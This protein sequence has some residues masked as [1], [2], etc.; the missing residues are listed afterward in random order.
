MLPPDLSHL[1]LVTTGTWRAW[2]VLSAD[3]KYRYL[4]GR[5][6]EEL[7]ADE[8]A[9]LGT[10]S[11]WEVHATPTI[12][13]M[14]NPSTADALTDDPTIRRCIGFARKSGR[15]RLVVANLFAWRA[16]DPKALT[17]TPDPVGPQNQ[18]AIRWAVNLFGDA[19]AAWG[20]FPSKRVRNLAIRS[21]GTAKM[22]TTLHCYGKTKDGEPRHPLMLPYDT[23]R[24]MLNGR[25]DA[26][27]RHDT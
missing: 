12:F 9:L 26:T 18:E 13:V 16:T 23:E 21:M 4:L 20:R 15:T 1:G 24:T 5:C 2:A 6:W 11:T 7:S 22:R 14:L 19:V 8:E 25:G 3:Q 10:G 17:K 27:A